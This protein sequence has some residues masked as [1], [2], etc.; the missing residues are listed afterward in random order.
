MP[1]DLVGGI[2]GSG[3]GAS[4]PTGPPVPTTGGGGATTTSTPSMSTVSALCRPDGGHLRSWLRL[5]FCKS[6]A[7]IDRAVERLGA[8]ADRLRAR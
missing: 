2:S 8:H 5:A 6:P 7:E 1:D 4:V 3:S